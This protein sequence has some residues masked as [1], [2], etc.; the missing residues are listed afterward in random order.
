MAALVKSRKQISAYMVGAY[1]I[2]QNSINL[3]MN[4]LV[5]SL[6]PESGCTFNT[7]SISSQKTSASFDNFTI[8]FASRFCNALISAHFVVF[9]SPST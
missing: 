3:A 8:S 6:F 2:F 5:P 4:F 7:D 9:F 1:I